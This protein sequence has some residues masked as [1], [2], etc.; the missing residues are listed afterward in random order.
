MPDNAPAPDRRETL[1]RETLHEVTLKWLARLEE[2]GSL[3]GFHAS[4]AHAIECVKENATLREQAE[5]HERAGK[6]YLK[7]W[8][9]A[10]RME[11]EARAEN[12]ALRD[13]LAAYRQATG[14]TG[15]GK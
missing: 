15:D 6:E 12:V 5:M 10:E 9:L 8:K 14:G 13:Q 4:L 7:W 3:S 11:G 2:N 1:E